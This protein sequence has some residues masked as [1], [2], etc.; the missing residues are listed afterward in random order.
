MQICA[1]AH[2]SHWRGV[3]L[4]T[5]RGAPV[6]LEE[7][8]PAP[9]AFQSAWRKRRAALREKVTGSLARGLGPFLRRGGNAEE[10]EAHVQHHTPSLGTVWPG[11]QAREPLMESWAVRQ[12]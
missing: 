7:A 9:P 5:G 3:F 12:Q 10:T 1:R 11:R 8:E 2:R 6:W 4:E